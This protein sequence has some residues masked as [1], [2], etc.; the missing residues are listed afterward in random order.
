MLSPT[1]LY[2]YH[3]ASP[4]PTVTMLSVYLGISG[5]T[6]R[7]MFSTPSRPNCPLTTSL[8]MTFLPLRSLWMSPKSQV[9]DETPE[10]K[11][12]SPYMK[13]RTGSSSL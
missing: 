10:I 5:M 13:T 6:V 9:T 11:H 3:F 7:N 2:L 1:F 4:V 12:P 8:R